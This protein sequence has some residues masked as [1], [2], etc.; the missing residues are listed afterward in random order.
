MQLNHSIID[1]PHEKVGITG[2]TGTVAGVLIQTLL[3]DFP[4]VEKITASARNLESPKLKR[5]GDSPKLRMVEGELH[6][7]DMLKEIAQDSD[8]VFHLAAWLANLELPGVTEVFVTNTLATGVLAE[9]CKRQGC[10]M[11]FTS[12]HSIYFGGEY[13]GRIKEEGFEFR[14]DFTTWMEAVKPAYAE[15]I[16]K[17]IAGNCPTGEIHDAVED[18]H[19][20]FPVPMDPLI[21]DRIDYHT[22]CIT[23]LM[24]EELA[25]DRGAEV[26]R[27]SNV[28]GPGDES[29][30]AVAE[31]C[32]RIIAAKPGE[33]LQINQPFKKLV[34]VYMGD[35]LTCLLNASGR[36]YPEGLRPV[37]TVASQENYMREDE[38]LRTVAAAMNEIKEGET[39][40]D[41][42]RLE[43]EEETA[44]TY[45]TS[46][47]QE[48]LLAG[49][50]PTPF[51]KGVKEQLI[52][53]MNR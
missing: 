14:E 3:E 39:R 28:Y 9:I 40:Y 38:L 6:E 37:F 2:A 51:Q 47:M 25:L 20:E 43:D 5:L 10:R 35:I 18:I 48:Y 22:Y 46:K 49:T 42:E 17:I 31:A 36:E 13:K 50:E 11:V 23:K 19:K 41:I 26:L 44:F 12:S 45:D 1:F 21:Y 33:Q 8:V 7:V 16:D 34:P 30:Q 27:L 53:L 29:V 4:Q 52:W 24:G 15:L 32:H